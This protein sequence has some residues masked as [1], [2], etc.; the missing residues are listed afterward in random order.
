MP[1]VPLNL[2]LAYRNTKIAHQSIERLKQLSTDGRHPVYEDHP[3][4]Q[5]CAVVSG[6]LVS[7]GKFVRYQRAVHHPPLG[8][9][10]FLHAL[11]LVKSHTTLSP[12]EMN[13]LHLILYR[14]S[15]MTPVPSSIDDLFIEVETDSQWRPLE[16]PLQVAT[17]RARLAGDQKSTQLGLVGIPYLHNS[18]CSKADRLAICFPATASSVSR[19]TRGNRKTGLAERFFIRVWWDGVET[20]RGCVNNTFLFPHPC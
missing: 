8:C 5:A 14:F 3:P 18:G 11:K 10:R 9:G 19:V 12:L 1:H 7:D 4:S 16:C 20:V 6:T 13:V 2:N 17:V 15:C